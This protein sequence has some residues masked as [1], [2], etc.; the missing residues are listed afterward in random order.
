MTLNPP[1]PK[2]HGSWV[3]LIVP[4]LLGF[5]LAPGWDW[6]GIILIVA[7]FGF[8]L[9][10]TPLATLVKTRK[11]KQTDRTYLWRWT[12][13]YGGITGLAGGWLVFVEG[14]WWL[15]LI[16]AVGASLILVNLWLVY[17]RQEMSVLSEL[18]G[19]FGLALGAP[20]AYYVTSD[21][22]NNQAIMLWLINGL[23]FGSTVFYVKLKVRQQPRKPIPPMLKVRL[24]DAQAGLIYQVGSLLAVIGLAILGE[25]PFLLPL[26]F[27]P[28]TF[29]VFYGSIWHWQDRKT[30]S[31][32]RLGV[33]E[34]IHAVIFVILVLV[35]FQFSIFSDNVM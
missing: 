29:K 27:L 25:I 22:L 3:M 28:A 30:L 7:A 21:I 34:I 14:L 13:I 17:K 11:R 20:M 9:V 10:R 33:I 16:G 8:F 5:S 23:Y 35:S 26:A 32:P 31:L 2:E 1:L 19:I 18:L 6:R 12:A 15:V 4:L 24:A